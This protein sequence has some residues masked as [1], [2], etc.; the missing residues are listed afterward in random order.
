MTFHPSTADRETLALLAYLAAAG[1]VLAALFMAYQMAITS[2]T[3]Q[4]A[5]GAST[6][7]MSLAESNVEKIRA[8]PA[9]LDAFAMKPPAPSAER[10]IML[11]RLTPKEV[12]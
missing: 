9:A 5:A 7:R 10:E 6:S 12:P 8:D 1:I 3:V 2:M 11:I 4:R